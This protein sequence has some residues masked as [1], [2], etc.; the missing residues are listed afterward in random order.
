MRVNFLGLQA[1]LSVAER[2]TFR[3]AAAHLNVSPTAV[4]HR[5]KKFE[6]ELGFKLF[7]RTTR[8]LS[9]TKAGLDLLTK[10]KKA[11]GEIEGSL[12]E[13]RQQQKNVRRLAIA[14]LPGFA[15]NPLP[16]I[17]AK[18]RTLY[19]DVQI[20][21]L[22]GTS[23][24]IAGMLQN[25]E[26]ELGIS[27]VST[28]RWNLETEP[29]IPVDTLVLACLRSHPLAARKSVEWKDLKGLP[30]IRVGLNTSIRP[31]IDDALGDLKE[32]LDWCY[33]VQR[34]ETAVSLVSKG[35]AVS[36]V[37]NSDVVFFGGKNIVSR[38]I[39]RPTVTCA[40]GL[41]SKKGAALSPSAERFKTFL[42]E[43]LAAEQ[44]GMKIIH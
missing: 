25:D 34:V 3:K 18:F 43:R 28:N 6:D 21:L 39:R 29:L 22:E 27:V 26:A 38:P 31:M 19:P 5:M 30:L 1:F 7:A 8:E 10:A 23:F 13:M 11:V 20:K 36:V 33:E 24:E 2:G 9:L 12:D 42:R 4:S 14:C 41:V 35:C 17:L 15:S 40:I 32:E 44:K 16:T 37:P